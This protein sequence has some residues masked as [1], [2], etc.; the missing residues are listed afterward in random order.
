MHTH[1]RIKEWLKERRK[2][3]RTIK[4][5]CWKLACIWDWL[6]WL[7]MHRNE[8]WLLGN[9]YDVC[10]SSQYTTYA[11]IMGENF[12]NASRLPTGFITLLC[13]FI[14]CISCRCFII[15]L[16]LVHKMRCLSIISCIIFFGVIKKVVLFHSLLVETAVTLIVYT[17]P[18]V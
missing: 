17:P 5:V 16:A 3:A 12:Y 8:P 1:A 18:H 6:L 15:M 2:S 14:L 13:T 4:Y 7:V 10:F 11:Y 9:R